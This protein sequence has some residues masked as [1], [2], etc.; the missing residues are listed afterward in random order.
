MLKFKQHKT[1]LITLSICLT[2]GLLLLFT[3]FSCSGD[4]TG[5][6]AYS[7]E[8]RIYINAINPSGT[9]FPGGRGP[10]EL[11]IYTT[12]HGMRTGTNQ[13]GL[14]A[15]VEEGRVERI[16]GNNSLIPSKGYIISGH[17][18]ALRWISKNLYPGVAVGVK[19][20][21]LHIRADVE[22]KLIYAQ[23]FIKKVTAV[24]EDSNSALTTA[25]FD[26]F[27]TAYNTSLLDTRLEKKN[28]DEHIFKEKA[29]QTP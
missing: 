26:S 1:I 4:K 12:V 29:E 28:P 7:D 9:E 22:S 10:D 19:L 2:A 8:N 5:I 21:S 15:V 17:G 13:Y 16:E 24:R 3:L 20:D 14:E 6:S 11:I 23:Y 25:R 18:K 27:T